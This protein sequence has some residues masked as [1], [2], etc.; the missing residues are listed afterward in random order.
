MAKGKGRYTDKDRK[1]LARV[2]AH[3]LPSRWEKTKMRS[4]AL[5]AKGT[6]EVEVFGS[7]RLMPSKLVAYELHGTHTV[8]HYQVGPCSY[9]FELQGSDAIDA[10]AKLRQLF[11]G[12][13]G[14]T[15]LLADHLARPA[16][17][18]KPKAKTKHTDSVGGKIKV[19][20]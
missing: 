18:A 17:D 1:V 7:L 11:E 16:E 13:E 20:P 5:A 2:R 6:A 15:M 3:C 12:A 4:K 10:A 14:R 9:R 8:M 19:T